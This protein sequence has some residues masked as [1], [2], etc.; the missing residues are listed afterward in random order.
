VVGCTA[1]DFA[2]QLD[3]LPEL[4]L[5]VALHCC[6]LP[7]CL[8]AGRT[9]P[10]VTQSRVRDDTLALAAVVPYGGPQPFDPHVVIRTVRGVDTPLLL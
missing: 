10:Q 8:S 4:H 5:P 7:Y 3:R 1:E 6:T 9:A 2:H